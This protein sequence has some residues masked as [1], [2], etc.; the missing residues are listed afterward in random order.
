MAT[1]ARRALFQRELDDQRFINQESSKKIILWIEAL[2][3][4]DLE[5]LKNDVHPNKTEGDII[6]FG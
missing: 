3:N 4:L 5:D 6:S 1:D 2:K